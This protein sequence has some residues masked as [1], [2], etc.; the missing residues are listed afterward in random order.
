MRH[1]S[2]PDAYVPHLHYKEQKGLQ[3]LGVALV[4][5]SDTACNVGHMQ[6]A[7]VLG[8]GQGEQLLLSVLSSLSSPPLH[9]TKRR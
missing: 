8:F 6:A 3:H 7:M 2:R 9:F 4:L 5:C 1:R